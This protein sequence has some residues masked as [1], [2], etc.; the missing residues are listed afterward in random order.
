MPSCC[1]VLGM[2]QPFLGSSL[3]SI[4][5]EVYLQIFCDVK[6]LIYILTEWPDV[7]ETTLPTFMQHCT[8]FIY[9]L[10]TCAMHAQDFF[11]TLHKKITCTM[12]AHHGNTQI[13]WATWPTQDSVAHAETKLHRNIVVGCTLYQKFYVWL[14]FCTLCWESFSF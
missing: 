4:V 7:V 1:S 11:S 5:K 8:T 9:R 10:L 6:E 14:Y 13:L 12:L 3:I 2:L